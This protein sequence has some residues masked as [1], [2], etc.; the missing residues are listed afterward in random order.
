MLSPYVV[1]ATWH[2]STVFG[3]KLQDGFSLRNVVE[4]V[5]V[6][7]GHFST[8]F[9]EKLQCSDGRCL[10]DGRLKRAQAQRELF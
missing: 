10:R 1:N 3:E 6:R 8:V 4:K 7:A 2:F 5:N 9:G